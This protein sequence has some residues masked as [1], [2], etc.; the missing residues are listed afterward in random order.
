MT[1]GTPACVICSSVPTETF[2][3]VTATSI[4]P[5]RFQPRSSHSGGRD[6]Q[7]SGRHLQ[8][9]LHHQGKRCVR[10]QMTGDAAE[11]QFQEISVLEGADQQ[12]GGLRGLGE[13]EDGFSH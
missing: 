4:S 9:M 8:L 13:I 12:A 7:S 3:N 11:K 5:G 2:L 6:N 1:S 10:Q